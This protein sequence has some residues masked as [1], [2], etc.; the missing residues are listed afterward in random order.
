MNKSRFTWGPK[1][2]VQHMLTSPNIQ[3][4]FHLLSLMKPFKNYMIDIHWFVYLDFFI[5]MLFLETCVVSW[6]WFFS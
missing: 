4:R 6:V 2:Q 5:Q 3:A 1:S